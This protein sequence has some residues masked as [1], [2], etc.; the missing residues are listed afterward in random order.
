[1]R[2]KYKLKH[3]ALFILIIFIFLS[4]IFIVCNAFYC[5]NTIKVSNYT[6][7]TDEINTNARFV[8]ISDL[9][10][11]EFGEKN[12]DLINKI[13][14]EKPDFIAVGG[15][16]VTRDYANNDSMKNILTQLAKIAPTYCILGNHELDLADQ[17]D[18][19]NDINNTGALLLDNKS[20]IFEKDGERILI[21]GLTDYPYYDLYAPDYNVPDRYFWDE[22]T[23]GAE[24]D[25]SILLH[26]QPEYIDDLLPDTDIDLVM[27]GHTH[28]GLIQIPF[29]GGL[30]APNQGLFPEYD[31]GEYMFDDT[32][33][34]VSSGLSVS[35][36]VPRINNPGEICVIDI[37]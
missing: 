20:V 28:G 27:C 25:F 5:A 7:N 11:K 12:C 19:E 23:K 16:M 14:A 13:K 29:A 36:F 10:N 34:I 33:M 31:L 18:F 35:N 4:S 8:F 3:K 6:L 30:V 24:S 21:G 2:N 17:L 9:H 1:M 32:K 15:D 37:N 22:F 26:H